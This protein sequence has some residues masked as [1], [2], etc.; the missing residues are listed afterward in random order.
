M[1]TS[2]MALF[3][4]AVMF[5]PSAFAY[6]ITPYVG[7]GIVVDKANT[8]AKRV[9]FDSANLPVINFPTTDL[10]A[11]AGAFMPN[12]GNDMDFDMAFAGEITAGVKID[13]VRLEAEV[14]LRSASEDDYKIFDGNIEMS[15]DG[16]VP[17]SVNI[18]TEIETATKV[19]H[20]SYLFNMFY[21]FDLGTRWTPYV[22]AGIGFGV[23]HQKAIVEIDIE[24]DEFGIANTGNPTVGI[25]GDEMVNG[26]LAE[27][28]QYEREMTVADDTL[29]RFEW[30][31]SAGIA[32][33]FN[34]DWALDL[35][36]R[37][38]SSTV[39]G[40]FVYAHEIKLGARY[41]F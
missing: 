9:A 10:G 35:G 36:Y 24:E 29:Y 30:Q 41:M 15:M 3:I 25:I 40:E 4:A 37:F 13:N 38:N 8:S 7:L 21:D 12:A 20:N 18:P 5:A 23:Y 16:S 17:G 39:G 33:N 32:Y 26:M 19:R 28:Q 27:L 11:V 6:E 14:A 34:E 22:G 31:V 2:K 1:K